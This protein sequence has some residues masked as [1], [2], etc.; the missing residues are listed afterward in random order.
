M[1]NPDDHFDINAAASPQGLQNQVEKVTGQ[2]HVPQTTAGQYAESV[3]ECCPTLSADPT[4][5]PPD[6]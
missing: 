6:C 3:G 1:G 5:W 2:F 4:A